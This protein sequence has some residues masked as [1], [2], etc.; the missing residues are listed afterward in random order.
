MFY[1]IQERL[2]PSH[3]KGLFHNLKGKEE[4]YLYCQFSIA[5]PLA[6]ALVR[7]DLELLI[8]E[9]GR[10]LKFLRCTLK[11]I[12]TSKCTVVLGMAPY[13]LRL[14]FLLPLFARHRV[15]LHTSW[16][17]WG[18]EEFVPKNILV[19]LSRCIWKI[20]VPRTVSGIFAV[21]ETTKV[22]IETKF[23]KSIPISVVHHS[24]PNSYFISKESLAKK[25]HNKR[26]IYIGRMCAEKGIP[27]I[28]K[29]AK[30]NRSVQFDLVGDGPL[31]GELLDLT[32]DNLVFH[33]QIH[34]RQQLEKII[35]KN[36]FVLQPS[37]N[38]KIWAEAFGLGVLE[39]M[40]RGLIP[41][42]SSNT[43]SIELLGAGLANLSC[44]L[45]QFDSQF[46]I[47]LKQSDG[48]TELREEC[49]ERA[50]LFSVDNA[51]TKFD[52]LF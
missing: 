5:R 36:S 34:Q 17:F 33:G 38:S 27:L 19:N 37:D 50:K 14:L 30:A 20:V 8:T 1:I 48:L 35:D 22:S 6:A 42:T 40:A 9:L 52:A 51:A 4:D 31:A 47:L 18:Q 12:F 16:P 43:G 44:D 29:L 2:Q 3:L 26:V 10:S 24:I 46:R 45:G 32:L 7:L 23:C 39:C 15:Y 28:I 21:S 25:I 41:I 13:D 49:F 11:I